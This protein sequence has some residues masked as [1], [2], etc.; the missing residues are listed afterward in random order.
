MI[1]D[2]LN[3]SSTAENY[4]SLSPFFAFWRNKAINSQESNQDY[5]T[6]YSSKILNV[7]R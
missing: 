2:A 3:I 7:W 5:E 6:N 1:L 4:T